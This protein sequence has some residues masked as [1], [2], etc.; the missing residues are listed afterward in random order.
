[1]A[2]IS[3]AHFF[4]SRN[5]LVL[6]ILPGGRT[7]PL[8][9]HF[10]LIKLSVKEWYDFHQWLTSSF[11][12]WKYHT[13]ALFPITSIS[14][15]FVIQLDVCTSLAIWVFRK[16]L[17]GGYPLCNVYKGYV[18]IH[19]CSKKINLYTYT[20]N[21]SCTRYIFPLPL[22][23]LVCNKAHMQKKMQAFWLNPVR[24]PLF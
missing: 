24:I 22:L 18:I 13:I 15:K 19:E 16:F 10:R 6:S 1:M 8:V 9:L 17:S 11:W 3:S 7:S 2:H 12:C 20:Q 23:F 4:L 21:T 14:D 5:M